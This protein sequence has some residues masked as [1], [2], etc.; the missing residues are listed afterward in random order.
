MKREPVP[1]GQDQTEIDQE[2]NNLRYL[3]KIR[4]R[5]S[6]LGIGTRPV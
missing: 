5:S 4:V 3:L 2:S 6:G 1:K